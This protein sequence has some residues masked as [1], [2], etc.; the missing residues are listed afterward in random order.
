[1]TLCT[2]NV[3]NGVAIV[4]LQRPEAMN[5]LSLALLDEMDAR[6]TEVEQREDIRCV[7]IAGAGTKA[8][9]AGADLKERRTMSEEQAQNAVGRIRTVIERI[10]ALEQPVIAAVAGVALGGGC[11]LALA[12]DVRVIAKD[13]V[14]GLTE[15]RLAIIPGAGGTQRMARLIGPG[16]AKD[17]ILTGR[18]ITGEEAFKLGMVERLTEAQEVLTTAVT[19]AQEMAQGGPIALRAA[20]AA[21]DHGLGRPLEEGLEI[22]RRAYERVLHSQDR[23]EG[24]TAFAQKRAPRYEGR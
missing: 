7:V 18:R 15:T 20:K 5:A 11:E 2:L 13:A 23:L 22:E 3:E 8:F 9:C 1:M 6:L 12:C 16:R 14:I 17:L 21:I 19:L 10:A 24:L 4:T